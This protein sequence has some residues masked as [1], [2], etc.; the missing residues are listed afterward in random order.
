MGTEKLSRRMF[1][2]SAVAVAGAGSL[3]PS[4]AAAADGGRG[5]RT[6]RA[7]AGKAAISIPSEALPTPRDK[8]TTVHD[9]LYARVLVVQNGGTEVAF[10]V[11]DLTGIQN[12]AVLASI[13]SI[14]TEVAGV[15]IANVLISVTHSF[16]APHVWDTATMSGSDLTKAQLFQ[17]NLLAATRA[18]ATDAVDSLQPARVGYGSGRAD[19]N[20][21][22][23][24]EAAD[25]WWL[26]T[27]EALPS[28]KGVRVTRFDD[29]D[30]NPFAI[31]A[32]Y[33][34]QSAVMM[35]SVMADGSLP[36]T[37]D[38]AGWT[39]ALIEGQY[40]GVTGFF[41]GGAT[42]D[43]FPA[44]RTV[45]Y[46]IDKDREWSR[47]DAKDAGWIL[48]TVQ[49]ERLGTEVVRVAETIDTSRADDGT[50]RL[51]TST[52]TADRVVEGHPTGPTT[53][54][55]W[56]PDGTIDVPVWVLR[57]GQGTFTGVMSELSTSTAAAM[58]KAAPFPH[59]SVISNL[60]GGAK[61]MAD[62]WNYE[63][64]TYEAMDGFLAKGTAEKVAAKAGKMLKS[65]R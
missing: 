15:P 57:I 32:N 44:F 6:L 13:R 1:I 25:G 45:R 41:L 29:L 26:G 63:H 53:N 46:T 7:G 9:D 30:G 55:T 48:L 64:I 16:S 17:D 11:Y 43:Q 4:D 34:V 60:G 40:E 54:Y 5:S 23:N 12:T 31:M 65:L 14:V 33:D 59:A 42:G 10:A 61:N 18:A 52:V 22:R 21:N 38:L 35:E 62:A 51:L 50:V 56:T 28:D 27:G 39:V 49:S 58:R 20:V 24:V 36:V 37:S 3:F 8:F 47:T 2:G 19:V